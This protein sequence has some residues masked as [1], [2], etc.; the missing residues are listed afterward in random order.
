MDEKLNILTMP[1]NGTDSATAMAMMNN[2][3]WMYLVMLALFGN[4]SFGNNGNRNLE[5]QLASMQNQIN[6]N[7]NNAIAR[8]AIQGNG[9]AVSQLAQN[10]NID[11]NAVREAVGNVKDAVFNLGAQ[12]GMGFA[13]VTNAISLGN[14]NLVQQLKDCCCASQKQ[15]L[16]QGYQGRI[17]TINQT[18]DLLTGIR[19]ENGLTRT[20]VAAFR[21]AWEN[22]RYQDVVAEKTRLQTELDLLRQSQGTQAAIA[23]A[24][25]PVSAELQLMKSNLQN[26]INT[27]SAKTAGNG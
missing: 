19:V 20:E 1:N 9:F 3:P 26:F 15:I 22:S 27:Y 4:G 11:S 12:N 21:Q 23:A 17:E 7:N 6:D 13:G 25:G 16:E 24:V 8:E 5:A 2:N 14:L 10:L 18:N